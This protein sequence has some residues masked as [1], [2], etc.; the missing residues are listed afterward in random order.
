M[1][2]C[3][4]CL[5]AHGSQEGVTSPRA[6]VYS[7]TQLPGIEFGSSRRA[8]SALDLPSHL[9]PVRGLVVSLDSA[10]RSPSLVTI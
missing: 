1:S 5:S 4:K 3:H 9:F 6:A 2:V 7:L 10:T 8:A